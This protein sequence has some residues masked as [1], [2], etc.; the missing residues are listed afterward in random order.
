MCYRRAALHS[1]AIAL[2][3]YLDGGTDTVRDAVWV[4]AASAVR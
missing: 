2:P 4:G 1:Q 3:S